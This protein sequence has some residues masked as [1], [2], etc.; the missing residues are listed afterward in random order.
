MQLGRRGGQEEDG[1]IDVLSCSLVVGLGMGIRFWNDHRTYRTIQDYIK[2]RFE[3][4]FFFS[5]FFFPTSFF[6]VI[7]IVIIA[8]TPPVHYTHG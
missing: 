6:D 8:D 5:I 1:F 4:L 7:I 3:I 2:V